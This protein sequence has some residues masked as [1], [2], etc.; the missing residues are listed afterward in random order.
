MM[1]LVSRLSLLGVLLTATAGSA[2]EL[3]K[4]PAN[5]WTPIKPTTVQPEAEDEK[6]QW[7]NVG[8]N[9]L[10][11]DVEGKRVLFYDR[12]Y[13]KKHGGTTI[14]GNCLFSF[15]PASAKLVPVRIDHWGKESTPTGGYRTIV[16]PENEK[17]PTPCPRH[18]YHAF[19]YVPE[20]KSVF[21]CNGANQSA[22]LKGEVLGHKLCTDT[23]RLDV[24]KKTWTKLASEQHPANQ[25]EDGMAYCPATKS[26]VYAGHG[27]VW[28]LDLDK[29]QWRKAKSELPRSHM[30][31][32]VHYDAPRKRILLAGGGAYGKYQTKAGGFNSL[33]AFDPVT[34]QITKLADCPTAL[35][36]AA[37]AHV[38]KHDLFITVAAFQGEGIEQPSGMFAYDPAKGAWRQLKP[39][40]GLPWDKGWLPLCYDK[41]H[42]CLIGMVKTTFY[43]FRYVPAK[44]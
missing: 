37:L 12:W 32:T 13:D 14:Y 25:L 18:V 30:G 21:I 4:L 44:D 1:L 35:C 28:I 8:W 6:G 31:M 36:R 3:E 16:L 29:G 19:D 42:D 43:A 22:M 15:D 38:V 27:K 17:E 9:K 2:A 26:I 10:V 39:A 5:T 7:M 23:W 11:Y 33:Y 34:E 24:D 40:D 20:L 41:Q